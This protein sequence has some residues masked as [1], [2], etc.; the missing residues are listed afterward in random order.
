MMAWDSG[1]ALQLCG[2]LISSH[3]CGLLGTNSGVSLLA[4]G[5]TDAA[6]VLHRLLLLAPI[7]KVCWM[8]EFARWVLMACLVWR[9]R[10]CPQ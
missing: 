9:W 2:L 6:C 4:G 3:C 7:S 1:F 10:Q 8:R 5:S